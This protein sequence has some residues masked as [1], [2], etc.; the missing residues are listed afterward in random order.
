MRSRH[1]ALICS[2]W[3]AL[4]L[5]PDA[6]AL[7]AAGQPVWPAP[8]APPR[9]RFLSSLT[10]DA[11]RPRASILTRILRVVAGRE[12]ERR[13]GQPY[14]VTV[15]SDGRVYV[16]DSLGGIVHVYD[17]ER[18]R[19]STI[20][21]EATTL[22]GIAASGSRLFA[23]DSVGVQVTCFDM[24]GR[25]QWRLGAKDG[26]A[27]PT[28]VAASPEAIYV[29]DTLQHRVVT[30]SP[31]GHVTGSFG[32]RGTGPGQ[33]NY[34][35]NI[36]RAPDGRLFVTDTLNFRVQI[37][38]ER[39]TPLGMFGR[40][41][42]GA[43]DFDKAKGIALDSGGHVYVVEGLHDRVAIFEPDGRVLLAFGGSGSG[44]GELWLPSGI[45]VANDVIYVADAANRRIQMF[46]YV[47]ERP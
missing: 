41:G 7:P 47:K 6:Q 5:R 29:V 18:R 20:R 13:M 12:P 25:V 35:T 45:A 11:I 32:E 26:F 33:F 2:V 1:L 19:Y 34:P 24:R 44:P 43:G 21:T 3:L 9:I 15:G 37:V 16:A 14:G 4:S 27:R 10:P 23:T 46:E 39:G 28:G 17:V 40:A 36:T 22:I 31:D 30:V 8:P 42:D 38:D